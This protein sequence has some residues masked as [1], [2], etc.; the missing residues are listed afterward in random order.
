LS[1]D[2]AKQQFDIQGYLNGKTS[3]EDNIAFYKKTQLDE[4]H[5]K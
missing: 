4:N 2:P 5:Q 3:T 1:I